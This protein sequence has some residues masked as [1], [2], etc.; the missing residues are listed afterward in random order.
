MENNNILLTCEHGG[1]KNPNN[2]KIPRRV[3][4]SHEGFDIGALDVAKFLARELGTALFYNEISRLVLD[5]NRSLHHPKVYSS[6]SVGMTLREKEKL[7][8]LYLAH[9]KNIKDEISFMGKHTIHLAIHSF[10]PVFNQVKRNADIGLLYD[11][12]RLREKEIALCMRD[13]LRMLGFKVRMNYPYLGKADGL[14]KYLRNCF[15][16]K[17]YAGIE[18][19]LNQEIISSNLVKDALYSSIKYLWM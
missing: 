7:E 17:E 15:S 18:I 11:P 19:E 12:A 14:T 3:L 1:N 16:D 9:R 2:L 4:E 8:H 6:F 5:F 10:T 13:F